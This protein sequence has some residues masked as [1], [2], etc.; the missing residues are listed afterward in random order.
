M[1]R[2]SRGGLPMVLTYLAL[3]VLVG[4]SLPAVV[5]SFLPPLPRRITGITPRAVVVL[6]AG[7]RQRKGRISLTTRGLRRL[8]LAAELAHEHGLPLLVSGGLNQTSMHD[9]EPTEADLMAEQ[10]LRRWPGLDVIKEFRSRN[11]WENACYSSEL[12]ADRGID[13]VL[14]VSDRAHLPRALLCF[15]SQGVLAQAAWSKRLPRQEWLP[16]AG[17]ISMVPE[18]WYEWLALVWYHAR[19]L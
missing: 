13:E 4:A 10:V 2:G 1:G 8:K 11:T 3:L 5:R 9:D 15:Q 17:A 16:S 14:L 19:F 7:R 6:G 12:L 18:I